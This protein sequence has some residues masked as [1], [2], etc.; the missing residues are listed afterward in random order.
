[1][2]KLWRD[3]GSAIWSFGSENIVNDFGSGFQYR[4]VQ[5]APNHGAI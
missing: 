4:I 2:E 1:L 5:E 3:F